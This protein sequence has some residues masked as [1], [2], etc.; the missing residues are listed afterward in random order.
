M[1]LVL[2][3][4]LTIISILASLLLII[5]II[6][7][8]PRSFF[9]SIGL[10]CILGGTVGNGMDRL[11]KGYVLDYIELV[12]INFPIFNV[13]DISINVAIICFIINSIITNNKSIKK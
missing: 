1:L 5:I 13:A 12:P 11:L 10:A 3:T 4:I 6:R 2:I 7:I 9:N 8:P